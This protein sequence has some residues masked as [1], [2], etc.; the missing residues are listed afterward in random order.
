MRTAEKRLTMGQDDIA[1]AVGRIEGR[2]HS[3]DPSAVLARGYAICWNEDG[4]RAIRNAADLSKGD[5]VRVTLSRG[6]IAAKVSK[7]E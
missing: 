1:A 3:L 6:A 7:I 2:L 4:T 5:T